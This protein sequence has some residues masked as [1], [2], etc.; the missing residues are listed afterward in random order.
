MKRYLVYAAALCLAGLAVVPRA[1]AAN[2]REGLS[3]FAKK[4]YPGCKVL[5]L[6][7]GNVMSRGGG[8]MI[9]TTTINK[10][11]ET[12]PGGKAWFPVKI[13]RRD[14]NTVIF[15]SDGFRCV[16]QPNGTCGAQ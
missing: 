11:P 8:N 5:W 16:V 3:G 9:L 7:N 12:L 10:C 1:E 6:G 15:E 2:F 14:K 4:G 13:D